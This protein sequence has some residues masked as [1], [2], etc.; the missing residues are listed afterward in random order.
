[1]DLRSVVKMKGIRRG[2]GLIMDR[3]SDSQGL[4]TIRNRPVNGQKCGKSDHRGC[5]FQFY[6]SF[7]TAEKPYAARVFT[8]CCGVV[9]PIPFF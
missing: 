7:T 3:D 6:H 2:G 4:M 8:I 5:R 1:M 9:F